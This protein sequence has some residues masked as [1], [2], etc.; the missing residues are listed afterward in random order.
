MINFSG[1]SY[2]AGGGPAPGQGWTW[3]GADGPVQL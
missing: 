2:I 1:P 3:K